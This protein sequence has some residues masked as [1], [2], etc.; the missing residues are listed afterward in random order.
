M[1]DNRKLVGR[2]VKTAGIVWA[3]SFAFFLF[4]CP[5]IETRTAVAVYG[6][7]NLLVFGAAYLRISCNVTTVLK[8]ADEC[9]QSMIDGEPVRMF[10]EEEESVLGKFQSRIRKLY[11]ILDGAR[12]REEKLHS[13]LS[14]LVADL[15]HQVN[16]PLTNI[17][18]Y[19]GFLV[20]DEL[21]QKDREQI[22]EVVSAQVE[23][24]GWFAEGFTKTMRLEDDIRRLN[25]VKQPL[26]EAVLAAVDQISLKAKENG[27]E[28]MFSGDQTACAVY[29]RRWTEE[30]VFNL[31]DNAVKYGEKGMPVKVSIVAYELF[32][33]IDITNYGQVIPES[34]YPKLFMRY[35]RGENAAFVKEGIGLGLYLAREIVTEQGGYIKVGKTGNIGNVFS[36][37]LRKS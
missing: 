31:L 27:N 19:C 1:T 20:Q 18:M 6:V 5:Q 30:A 11:E 8:K 17:Q 21:P 16:T 25:P 28:V 3:I 32:V 9:V 37:F 35:Y 4:I 26:A 13:E 2:T 7:W 23:K 22:A 36:V 34:E 33:R 24:L 14:A 12:E 15:V 10:S 29:D